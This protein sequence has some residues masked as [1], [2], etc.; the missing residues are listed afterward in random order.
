MAVGSFV[1]MAEPPAGPCPEGSFEAPR[2]LATGRQVAR[3][4]GHWTKECLV[5]VKA[6]GYC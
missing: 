6:G 3:V 5:V 1:D 2:A 4:W